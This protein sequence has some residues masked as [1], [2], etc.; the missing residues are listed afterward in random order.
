MDPTTI[1]YMLALMQT[2]AE[3]PKTMMPICQYE[4]GSE[5]THINQMCFWDGGKNSYV[6]VNVSSPNSKIVNMLYYFTN[7]HIEIG[8]WDK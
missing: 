7:G 1:V 3:A 2:N 4:D 6:A 5:L 8:S